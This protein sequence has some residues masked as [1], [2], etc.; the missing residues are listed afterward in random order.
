MKFTGIPSFAPEILMR[1]RLGDPMRAKHL[2][3]ALEDLAEEGVTQVFRPQLGAEWIVGVVG[4]L[5]LDVLQTRLEAEYNLPIGF[6]A[7]PYVTARWCGAGRPQGARPVPCR[8]ARQP[9]P[10]PRRQPGL[11]RPQQL[12][13]GP[14]AGGLPEDP[15]HRDPRAALSHLMRVPGYG[16]LSGNGRHGVIAGLRSGWAKTLSM[17]RPSMSITS[18][19]QLPNSNMS[20][21]RGKRPSRAKAK[22]GDGVVVAPCG[23]GELEQLGHVVHRLPPCQQPRAV[24]ALDRVRL[25]VRL[26]GRKLAGDRFQQIGRGDEALEGAV[27]VDHERH[28]DR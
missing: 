17:R 26:M 4:Q 2:K 19:R 7:A 28:V 13:P 11:P 25:G 9:R 8:Q 22:P 14:G 3:A 21:S 24:L 12:G 18:N 1:V 20:P 23:Q 27:L 6:E 16:D 15:L 10:G 5:Q